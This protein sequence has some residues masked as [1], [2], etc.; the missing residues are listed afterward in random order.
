MYMRLQEEI[1]T[2]E[3][4]ITMPY[5]NGVKP[6]TELFTALQVSAKR[7]YC[8]VRTCLE[9]TMTSKDFK[10]LEVL[11]NAE[12]YPPPTDDYR[13]FEYSEIQ[14]FTQLV[15]YINATSTNLMEAPS[16]T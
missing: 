9:K 5:T 6:A 7:L 8:A 3:M 15:D 12:P 4:Y 10:N 1:I 14:R 11:K 2:F 16:S 13:S